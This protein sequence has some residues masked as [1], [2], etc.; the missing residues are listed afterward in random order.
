MTARVRPLVLFVL[1]LFAIA[2]APHEVRAQ[3][4]EHPN[5]DSLKERGDIKNLPG[6]LKQRIIDLARRPHTFLPLTVFSEAPT[7]SRLFGYF[8]LDTDHFQ[9]NVFTATI[10][11]INDGAV[12]TGANCANRGLPTLASVRL[13]VE[14]KPGLPTDPNDPGAFIDIFTDISGLFVIN[15]ES[16]WYEGWMIHD[17]EVPSVA[18]PRA[19]GTLIA[20]TA[21]PDRRCSILDQGGR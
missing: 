6:P 14:P 4:N 12:P 8:L 7:P 5:A 18:A 1:V 17:L 16:G 20:A 3:G 21:N 10:P 19:D 11:G 13:V 15:N 9:P 2:L